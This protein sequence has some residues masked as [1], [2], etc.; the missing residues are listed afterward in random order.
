MTSGNN[1]ITLRKA[2]LSDT[3]A[4]KRLADAHRYELGFI[5]RPTIIE[6]INRNELIV[7]HNSNGIVGFVEYHHRRDSQTSLYHIVV[8]RDHRER[9]IGRSLL[10]AVREEARQQGKKTVSMKCPMDLPANEFYEHTGCLLCMR[11]QGKNRPLVIWILP[12]ASVITG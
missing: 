8:E 1:D 7:A 12:I 11:V 6:S 2:R 5:R 3:D 10:E 4:V 9:G